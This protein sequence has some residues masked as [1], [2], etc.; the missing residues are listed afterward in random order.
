M[1]NI[2]LHLYLKEPISLGSL[3]QPAAGKK[4]QVY[5]IDKKGYALANSV[6]LV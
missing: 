1:R 3:L 6:D 4:Y 5:P 2:T